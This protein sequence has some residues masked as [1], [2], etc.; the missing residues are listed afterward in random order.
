MLVRLQE[1]PFSPSKP[2][3]T[4]TTWKIDD[5][6]GDCCLLGSLKRGQCL[7]TLRRG[8]WFNGWHSAS[9]CSFRTL[10]QPHPGW[11]GLHLPLAPCLGFYVLKKVTK[12]MD[13]H[14]RKTFRILTCNDVCW[15]PKF[16]PP[17]CWIVHN[18]EETSL[19]LSLPCPAYPLPEKGMDWGDFWSDLTYARW[20]LCLHTCLFWGMPVSR[21]L[22]PLWS[23][24]FT[25]PH[26]PLSPVLTTALFH[27]SNA[28]WCFPPQSRSSQECW[29]STSCLVHKPSQGPSRSQHCVTSFLC[30]RDL[31]FTDLHNTQNYLLELQNIWA[32]TTTSFY[33]G[34]REKGCN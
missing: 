8:R 27:H 18:L 16:P 7:F 24:S 34:W 14:G 3:A 20:E 2:K 5:W 9:G 23:Y 1:Q 13:I 26:T 33:Q 4:H 17:N 19:W 10:R 12:Q 11:P 30:S 22:W 15:A 21:L 32:D 25:S 29:L 31:F 28:S 6:L